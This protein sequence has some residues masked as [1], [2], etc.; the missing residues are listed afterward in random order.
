MPDNVSAGQVQVT[1]ALGARRLLLVTTGTASTAFLPFWLNWLRDS[2]PGLE[3]RAVL[4]VSAQRFVTAQSLSLLLGVDVIVDTWPDTPR[5]A[6]LHVELAEW[7]EVTAVFPATA[8]F[9]TRL[10]LGICDTPVMLALQCTN[11]TVGLAPSVPPGME[12]NPAYQANLEALNRRVNVVVART[13]VGRGATTGRYDQGVA[14]PMWELIQ[15]IE[16]RRLALA[17]T[18]EGT[19]SVPPAAGNP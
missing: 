2:Y 9:I 4:T 12:A 6:A 16:K 7:A 14:A 17:G 10:A 1:P 13:V 15:L 18:A 19:P 5:P 8:G 3:V 11:K